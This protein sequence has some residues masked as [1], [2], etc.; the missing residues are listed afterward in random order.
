MNSLS[1]VDTDYDAIRLSLKTFLSSNEEFKDYDFN[2]S[3]MA[4]LLN[5]LSYNTYYNNIYHS[6]VANERF[7]DSAQ[8]RASVVS[9]AK[10][11]GYVPRS[12]KGASARIA[13]QLFPADAPASLS[14][15]KGTS[16]KTTFNN[17]DYTFSVPA[18]TS[19][20]I[21]STGA[22]KINLDIL[23]GTLVTHKF[24]VSS[25]AP[26][27]YILPNA[28]ID[29]S[30]IEVNI[31]TSLSDSTL[32]SF[33]LADN[34]VEVNRDSKIF[35]VQEVDNEYIE[36]YFG[37]GV[38][39]KQL[40]DGN[41]VIVNYRVCSG[42]A[43]NGANT[44]S[45]SGLI[46]GCASYSISTV[47]GAEGGASTES[48]TSIKFNAPKNFETQNRAVIANDYARLIMRDNAD[49][50][51]INVWGGEENKPP[52]YG[53][54]YVCAKP[55]IGTAFSSSRK[56][57][58]RSQLRKY[59]MLAVDIEFVD[60]TYLYVAPAIEVRYDPNGTTLSA[61]DISMAIEQA[62]Q[63]YEETNI[64]TF[65]SRFIKSNL[66]A[67]VSAVSS[68]I[69][70][71]TINIAM[72]KRFVPNLVNATTYN[73]TFNNAISHPH[74]GHI[75]SIYSS[76]FTYNAKTCYFGD[77]G[78]GN[79][80][81]F[82]NTSSNAKVVINNAAGT[83]DYNTGLINL[84]NLVISNFSGNEIKL[85]AVPDKSVVK[86]IRNQLLL[87]ADASVTVIDDNTDIV[88]NYVQQVTTAG[89]STSVYDSGITLVTF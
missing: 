23:E 5:L 80:T 35:F 89:V 64:G 61:G 55:I 44:F 36:I 58:L 79:M 51:A 17:L 81:I 22:Y 65:A 42:D 71:T 4:I 30:S 84:N 69:K 28:N 7:L 63:A 86:S 60:P 8:L 66:M 34:I 82:Y 33:A 59:N 87:L 54:V 67:S 20:S 56:S 38:I 25:T 16:F 53:K 50:Q 43:V 45:S 73:V 46:A 32:T 57:L 68:A 14:I 62:I 77:D 11:L 48:I 21:D 2:D 26:V 88:K 75:G 15:D 27:K 78:I 39:G 12:A 85:Y 29:T 72:Q 1:V 18:T 9:K 70:S 47:T 10:E 19:V 24:A 83:V 74:D 49:V 13:L 37:D 41:I 3:T 52:I 40:S 6:M 31:Q 76:S